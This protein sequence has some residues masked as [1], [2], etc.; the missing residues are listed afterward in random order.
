M[1]VCACVGVV[2]GG[3]EVAHTCVT[4]HSCL[5]ANLVCHHTYCTTAHAHAG[6]PTSYPILHHTP[7][8]NPGALSPGCQVGVLQRAKAYGRASALSRCI[9]D[10]VFACCY[11]R[12]DVEVTKKMNHL[13]KVRGW[14]CVGGGGG[15]VGEESGW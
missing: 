5:L 7:V 15:G 11:P 3:G 8:P 2:Q 12:L 10:I 6:Q 13:L 14:V 1:C 9:P 4:C